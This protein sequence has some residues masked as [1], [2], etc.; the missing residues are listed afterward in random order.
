MHYPR[1][2]AIRTMQ[3]ISF[4][5]R[6][7]RS[8]RPPI[9]A[10]EQEILEFLSQLDPV[11]RDTIKTCLADINILHGYISYRISNYH[12]SVLTH[13]LRI[14]CPSIRVYTNILDK[15]CCIAHYSWR[16][17]LFVSIPNSIFQD[18]YSYD[19]NR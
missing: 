5:C 9:S 1:P 6:C 19:K 12:A 16:T 3:V 14:L 13:V 18:Y 7:C 8:T 10:K 11:A 4:F 15:S 2:L 17:E